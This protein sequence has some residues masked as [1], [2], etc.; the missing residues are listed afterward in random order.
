MCVWC[1]AGIFSLLLAVRFPPWFD[2]LFQWRVLATSLF[3]W[4][5]VSNSLTA[6]SLVCVCYHTKAG[7]VSMGT[8][9]NNGKRVSLLRRRSHA[10]CFFKVSHLAHVFIL[11]GCT[12]TLIFREQLV[13]WCCTHTVSYKLML[14]LKHQFSSEI[15]KSL[16]ES[17]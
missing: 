6:S 10:V 2:L 5:C 7:S 1:W 4:T 8:I 14:K 12:Q 16:Y 9:A 3:W 15:W 13:A 17:K 11:H